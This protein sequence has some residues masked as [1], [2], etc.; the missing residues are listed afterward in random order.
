MNRLVYLKADCCPPTGTMG[1]FTTEAGRFVTVPEAL[2]RA[3]VCRSCD[4]QSLRTKAH[5]C[6]LKLLVGYKPL[7]V[8]HTQSL[9]LSH[10]IGTHPFRI[11]GSTCSSS[12]ELEVGV[13][14]RAALLV[15]VRFLDC[16]ASKRIRSGVS[17]SWGEL[18]VRVGFFAALLFFVRF[19]DCLASNKG[20]VRMNIT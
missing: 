13:G 20:H 19:L 9:Q 4:H 8:K 18:E 17:G 14:F 15:F 5:F 1:H 11:L 3:F 2:S 6:S 7:L 12:W 10:P 16:L